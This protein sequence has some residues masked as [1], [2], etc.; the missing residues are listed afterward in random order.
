MTENPIVGQTIRWTF[1]DGPML[2]KTFEHDF[3]RNGMVTWRMLDAPHQD[4][5]GSTSP[6]AKY[7]FETVGEDVYA[8]SYLSASGY[9]LTVVLDY[10]TGRLVAFA[11]NE[12]SISVQHG[13]F[14]RS[15]SPPRAR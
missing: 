4:K 3:D 6:A 11:S 12:Q 10:R 7:E 2:G 14:E 15:E 8:I 9:T 1:E 5:A 13:S